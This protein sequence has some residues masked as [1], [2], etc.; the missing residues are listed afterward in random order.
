MLHR[1][2][3]DPEQAPAAARETDL[4]ASLD[5]MQSELDRWQTERN[6]LRTFLHNQQ[7][8]QSVLEQQNSRLR[9]EHSRLVDE[10][11]RLSF[12]LTGTETSS[13]RPADRTSTTQDASTLSSLASAIAEV[14]RDNYAT[15]GSAPE[16]Q[17]LYD[18]AAPPNIAQHD[19]EDAT[20]P[21]LTD[22]NPARLT[23]LN[24]ALRNYRL[25]RNALRSDRPSA[26][27]MGTV[28]TA[29]ALREYWS[30]EAHEEPQALSAH[31]PPFALSQFV[32]NHRRERQRRAAQD[33][34]QAAGRPTDSALKPSSTA[35]QSVALKERIHNTI[36]YLSKLRTTPAE[37]T[38]RL[39]RFLELDTLY[40]SE[41]ANAPNDLP[42]LIDSLPLPQP[43]SWL[44]PGMTWHGLQSTDREQRR[45]PALLSSALRRMRQR[46]YIGRAMARRGI[47]EAQ[48]TAAAMMHDTSNAPSEEQQQPLLR[49]SS[50]TDFYR[51]VPASLLPSLINST[52]TANV[53]STSADAST[54]DHWPVT[55]TLHSVDYE[56]MEVTG[57]MR[58]SQIP[59]HRT[60][61]EGNRDGNS[62]SMESFF[63]GEIID[64]RNHTLKTEGM[65][66]GYL[67]G[68]VDV[69]ARYW[70]RVGPFKEAISKGAMGGSLLDRKM[71][72]K[73]N[74][75]EED[76]DLKLGIGIA[77][78]GDGVDDSNLDRYWDGASGSRVGDGTQ[79]RRELEADQVM[80][81]CVGSQKWLK[82]KLGREWVLM[83]WKGLC[84][85]S[86][87]S[88]SSFSGFARPWRWSAV[89]ALIRRHVARFVFPA[90]PGN[91]QNS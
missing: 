77:L 78:G 19:P 62:R 54:T 86:F 57:T 67:A 37:A 45:S 12:S 4:A 39:A 17:R 80:M 72:R 11:S 70:A 59:D 26:T 8:R 75:S 27:D 24:R 6:R 50:S 56:S 22:T 65:K 43:T 82:E 46:E 44:V 14:G 73:Y 36:H 60:G 16:R 83:R 64:F 87:S 5:R 52:S 79:E 68:G 7:N 28:P 61:S 42:L 23:E 2:R 32:E 18:W 15:R 85:P 69:D 53:S 35:S 29:S 41:D 3:D 89:L 88:A 21:D 48:H 90:F 33:N 91:Q 25:A 30:E 55:V 20:S 63:R 84:F 38:L 74:E 34:A 9:E 47:A 51:D 66:R 10:H 49:G 1:S 31:R 81:R 71:S 40:E 58:A 76:E 13:S